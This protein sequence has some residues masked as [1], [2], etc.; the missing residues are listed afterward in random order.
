MLLPIYIK[1]QVKDSKKKKTLISHI[2]KMQTKR[3]TGFIWSSNTVHHLQPHVLHYKIDL[4]EHILYVYEHKHW[5][6][7]HP[8]ILFQGRDLLWEPGTLFGLH[9][10]SSLN[11]QWKLAPHHVLIEVCISGKLHCSRF[12]GLA[13]RQTANRGQ[14]SNT[15]RTVDAKE[16]KLI[17]EPK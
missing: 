10:K 15:V 16:E 1:I 8:Y 17:V 5:L 6:R 3:A 12:W 13:N 14:Q 11:L 7:K 4:S 9:L 2:C